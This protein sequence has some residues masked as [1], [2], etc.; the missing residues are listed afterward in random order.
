[1]PAPRSLPTITPTPLRRTAQSGPTSTGLHERDSIVTVSVI[2]SAAPTTSAAAQ[3]SSFPF[4]VAIPALVGGMALAVLAFAIY[5]WLSRKQKE[6][7]RVSIIIFR[8]KI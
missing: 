8:A 5:W 6:E 2:A 7:K 4:A 3:K 1:M